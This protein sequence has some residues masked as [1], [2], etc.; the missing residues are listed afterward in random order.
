MFF[1]GTQDTQVDYEG[2][3]F[4]DQD[5]EVDAHVQDDREIVEENERAILRLIPK[6]KETSIHPHGLCLG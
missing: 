4:W 2:K 1:L 6:L 5:L 3:T